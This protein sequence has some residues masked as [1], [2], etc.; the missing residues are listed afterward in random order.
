VPDSQLTEVLVFRYQDPL[1]GYRERHDGLVVRAVVAFERMS[2]IV[3]GRASRLRKARIA[4]LVEQ[5]LHGSA[6]T[7]ASSA[8]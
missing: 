5:Q 4:A 8:R 7:T 3:S 1:I 6:R 2:H